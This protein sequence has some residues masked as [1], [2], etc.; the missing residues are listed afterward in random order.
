M[1]TGRSITRGKALGI[2]NF[3]D[4]FLKLNKKNGTFDKVPGDMCPVCKGKPEADKLLCD[5]C[6]RELKI[7][8]VKENLIFDQ[9][10]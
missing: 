8:I 10:P 3:Q 2:A 9:E 1:K 5:K 6:V 7:E 4:V